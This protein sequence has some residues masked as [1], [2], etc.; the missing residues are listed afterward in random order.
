[1]F[2]SASARPSRA[3][4]VRATNAKQISG[5]DAD[6]V[7][8]DEYD[9][10]AS[11]I[12]PLARKR[13]AASQ[14]PRLYVASTP[15]QPEWGINAL[16]LESDQQRCWLPCPACGLAQ[17]LDWDHNINA[18][19]PALVCRQCRRPLD[20]NAVAAWRPERPGNRLRGYHL[21]RLLSPRCNLARMLEDSEA[22]TIAEAMHFQT[23]DLGEAYRA[24]GRRAFLRRARRL[25]IGGAAPRI[26]VHGRG[27]GQ[28][29]ARRRAR[30]SGSRIRRAHAAPA[31]R[32]ALRRDRHV[33]A[34]PAAD[35]ALFR[36]GP[37]RDRR[38]TRTP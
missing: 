24:G 6:I 4:A 18:E 17:R 25:P 37:L 5:V 9:Q 11:D 22:V 7:I 14:Q 1:M 15:T 8:L 10:M 36:R 32:P 31:Q 3:A 16:F 26:R 21:P 13:Q 28:I 2:S 20:I 27:C 35:H 19:G 38:R 34:P 29:P 33:L 12:L 23:Q 30:V